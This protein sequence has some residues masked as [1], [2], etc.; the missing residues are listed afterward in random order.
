[1]ITFP[2]T[3]IGTFYS[4]ADTDSARLGYT[5]K[6]SAMSEEESLSLLLQR[7]PR[8]ESERHHGRQIA[9]VLGS[10][11]LAL[12]QIGAY[13]R[14]H[15]LRLEEFMNLY[16]KRKKRILKEVPC[17]WEYRKNIDCMKNEITMNAFTTWELSFEQICDH[18]EGKEHLLTLAAF[19]DIKIVS[20]RYFQAHFEEKPGWMDIFSS[21]S[22]WDTDVFRDVLAEFQKLSL[23]EISDE[24]HIETRFSIHPVVRDW[25]KLRISFEKLPVFAV[26]QHRVVNTY[27]RLSTV[28]DLTSEMCDETEAHVDASLQNYMEF[29]TGVSETSVGYVPPTSWCQ[30][31]KFFIERR[32]YEKA[33]ELFQRVL[34]ESEAKLLGTKK[35][36]RLS[37]VF[38]QTLYYDDQA[39]CDMMLY[40]Y[41]HMLAAWK[42]R[43]GK[44]HPY[45]TDVAYETA[46]LYGYD[47]QYDAAEKL[48]QWVLAGREKTLGAKHGD[49]L[50]TI[51][52]FAV[53][54][55]TQ[56]KYDRYDDVE[57]LFQRAL[58]GFEETLGA[59]DFET[60]EVARQL[61]LV[62]SR[63]GRYSEAE[64]LF[65]RVLTGWKKKLSI[66]RSNKRQAEHILSDFYKEGSRY[67]QAKAM[68]QWV[69]ANRKEKL[70][71]QHSDTLQAQKDL[72]EYYGFWTWD[73]DA[74]RV[75]KR[76]RL[77]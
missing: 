16:H 49:T 32:H 46:V 70:G 36:S 26:V 67:D 68:F 61:V 3:K 56:R 19:F 60:L 20:E 59:E 65:R 18:N 73:G 10:L 37:Q 15:L 11:A 57:K 5:I 50:Q 63:L 42:E 34:K 44:S 75:R 58:V 38:T 45:T 21:D 76:V 43:L 39:R 12:S 25:I 72:S 28:P 33:E 13:I 14:A 7:L 9:S 4:P 51:Y 2:V 1:M 47:A 22:Q 54:Y 62:N 24:D 55:R 53:L 74:K 64:K 6:V 31:A 8:T 23:L 69:L 66:Q 52:G 40:I 35:S 30:F 71:A 17:E 77:E 29:L 41:Q 27:L 48:F